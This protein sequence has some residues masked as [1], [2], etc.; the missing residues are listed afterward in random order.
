[1]KFVRDV[2]RET[3]FEPLAAE[4]APFLQKPAPS[5]LLLFRSA[6][7]EESGTADSGRC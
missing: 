5:G 7:V 2:G 1:M 4:F 6:T 3:I